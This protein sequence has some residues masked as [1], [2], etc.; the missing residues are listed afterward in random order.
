MSV[1][2]IYMKILFSFESSRMP[3]RSITL[4]NWL[5]HRGH[6]VHILYEESVGHE[7]MSYCGFN[8]TDISMNHVRIIKLSKIKHSKICKVHPNDTIKNFNDYDIWFADILNYKN[9]HQ[10]SAYH[11]D[12]KTFKNK[13][14]IIS[15]DDGPIFFDHRLD[16]ELHERVDCWVNNLLERDRSNYHK[17]IQN[18]CML[19]PTYIEDSNV[20]Y[21]Q[22][23]GS[24]K[25][26]LEKE[27][28]SYF[29]GTITG[30]LPGIDCRIS[31]IH[32]LCKSDVPYT[33]RIIGS[34]TSSLILDSLHKYYLNDSFKKNMVDST[35][36]LNEMNDHK[37]MLSPKGNCQ[38]VRRQ[39]ESF[40]FNNLVFINE[41]NVVDYLFEG[42]PNVHFVQYKLDCSDLKE[43][44]NYYYNN[45]DE[46]KKIA[47]AGTK[48]WEENC[49]IYPDGSL[50]ESVSSYLIDN[51]KRITDVSL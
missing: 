10:L 19:I 23:K 4:I 6:T 42:T 30:C 1:K 46:A 40:A 37:F 51:F 31:S 16:E 39:Y 26:F 43:K 50:S 20:Y 38:P 32:A 48:F 45:L 35:T 29:S 22:F 2:N 17:S 13:L 21:D 3:V 11:D 49:R 47:D 33:I 18:K 24:I 28:K 44:I 8:R 12:F 15:F 7:P 27:S 36:Y 9:Y 14:V 25:P 34:E 5:I 41:N